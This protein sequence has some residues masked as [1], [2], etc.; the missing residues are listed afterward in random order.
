MRGG[1]DKHPDFLDKGPRP[2]LN[3]KTPHSLLFLAA[4]V[5]AACASPSTRIDD[6]E[7]LFNSYTP[8]ER[9]LIRSGQVAVGFDQD[10]VRMALGEP[11]RVRS[12]T[13]VNGTQSVWEYRDI[14]INPGVFG[15]ATIR[16]G[17]D[18]GVGAGAAPDNRLRK[19]ITFDR[20]TGTVSRVESYD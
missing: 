7:A 8:E 12:V 10:Q 9:R 15:S 3:V 14:Q 18:A 20:A 19:R 11:S 4:L 2:F 16:R 5:L 17:A 13:T 6:N 1:L